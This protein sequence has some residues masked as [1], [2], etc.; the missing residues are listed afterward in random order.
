MQALENVNS[1]QSPEVNLK[2]H[3]K[4]GH[5]L[6]YYLLYKAHSKP[7]LVNNLPSLL[8]VYNALENGAI[9]ISIAERIT[10]IRID[11]GVEIFA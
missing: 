4:L 9:L 8:Y 6:G 11:Q 1:R 10:D 7:M 2:L 5:R 3:W